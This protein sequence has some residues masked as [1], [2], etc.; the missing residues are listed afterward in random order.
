MYDELI[1]LEHDLS[2]T[3]VLILCAINQDNPDYEHISWLAQYAKDLIDLINRI[4]DK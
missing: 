2:A 1:G 3:H 4:K